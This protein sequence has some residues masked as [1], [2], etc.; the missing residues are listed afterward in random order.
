[1]HFK[2]IFSH[3]L[4]ENISW[5]DMTIS[6]SLKT[7][8]SIHLMWATVSQQLFL[9]LQQCLKLHTAMWHYSYWL[10]DIFLI[11]LMLVSPCEFGDSSEILLC[12]VSLHLIFSASAKGFYSSLLCCLG[13]DVLSGCYWCSNIKAA[14]KSTLILISCWADAIYRH[15]RNMNTD[16]L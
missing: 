16:Y 7:K 4:F 5:L 15:L 14:W 3:R 1:M 9:I 11:F 13:W 12:F 8:P 6:I 10:A 2:H